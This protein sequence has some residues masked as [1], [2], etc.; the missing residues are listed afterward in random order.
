[1]N[2]KNQFRGVFN[3][4]VLLF[5]AVITIIMMALNN[6]YGLE[7]WYPWVTGIIA[8]IVASILVGAY[9][10]FVQKEQI[11]S[12]HLKIM[13]YLNEKN[14]S[15]IIKYYGKF[16]ESVKDIS[17][18]VTKGNKVDIYLTYGYTILNSLSHQINYILSKEGS[19]VNIYIMGSNNPFLEAYSKFWYGDENTD[20][21]NK[22]IVETIALL[23][24]KNRNSMNGS[25]NVFFN[26]KSPVNYS[27]YLFE[28]KVFY[29]PTKNTQSKEFSPIT[30]LAQKTSVED[31]LFN[32]I[33]YEL[34]IMKEDNCF[35]KLD[36]D[37]K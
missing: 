17:D 19:E 29:V 3:L 13:E 34:N 33:R 14:S 35:K 15:G 28:D 9:Y 23:K 4:R 12:E 25:L 11:S 36:L 8:S 2:K 7:D 22:K 18:E 5:V 26:E 20:K 1:M 30:I 37:E 10:E 21:L 16:S 6:C 24:N 32:K 31:S 27:F